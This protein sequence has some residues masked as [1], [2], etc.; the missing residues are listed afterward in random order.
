MGLTVDNPWNNPT[1]TT[2]LCF[3]RSGW[4]AL[5]Y[6]FNSLPT[7]RNVPIRNDTLRRHDIAPDN[8]ICFA[9]IHASCAFGELFYILRPTL[10]LGHRATNKLTPN[11]TLQ[12][13]IAPALTSCQIEFGE[14]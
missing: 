9:H 8:Q 14:N 1:A 6:D 3:N 7:D 10:D 2:V 4:L 5:A 12:E 11:T 13:N